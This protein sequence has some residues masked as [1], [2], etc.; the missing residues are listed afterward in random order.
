LGLSVWLLTTFH[1]ELGL[2][3]SSCPL[4]LHVNLIPLESFIEIWK[5]VPIEQAGH[6]SA[7]TL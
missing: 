6:F 5:H 1:N 7:L 4:T 2:G 3:K